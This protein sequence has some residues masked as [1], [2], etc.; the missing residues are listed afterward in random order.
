[1]KL[2]TRLTTLLVGLLWTGSLMATEEP[3]FESL[4][5]EDNVEIRLY[6]PLIVAETVVDGDMDSATSQGFRRIAGYIFGDNARIAMTAPVVAEPQGKAEKIAMTAPVSIEPQ[7]ADGKRMAGAQS[8]RIHFV[9]PSQYTMATLPKP[10]DPQVKLRE[11]P[12]RTYAAL[13][14][15]G[16]NSESAVQEKTDELLDWLKAQA[17]ETV[18]KPQL[19]RYNPP[20]TLPFLRRNEILQEIK[21][22]QP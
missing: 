4:R 18:G 22:T 14:Y 20:W 11:I 6:A 8:W 5:K 21:G 17:I 15:T 2:Q 19:A 16:F 1:M 9:M 3:K 7:T 13:T 10:L 12:A